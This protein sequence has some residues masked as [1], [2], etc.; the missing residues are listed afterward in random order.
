VLDERPHPWLSV[1]DE[2]EDDKLILLVRDF[3]RA[4]YALYLKA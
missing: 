2:A 1:S 4:Q 3:L